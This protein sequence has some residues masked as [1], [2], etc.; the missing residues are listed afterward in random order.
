MAAIDYR[1]LSAPAQID[2]STFN[3]GSAETAQ[4]LA[5]AFHSFSGDASALG[6]ALNADAGAK[7]GGA[8]GASDNPAPKEGI[9]KYTAYSKAYNHSAEVA[10]VSKSQVDAEANITRIEQ[11]NQGNLPAYQAAVGGYIKGMQ[12]ATPTDYWPRLQPMIE[13]RVVAGAA[14][15]HGQ[16]VNEIK[17]QTLDT[18]YQG[19]DARTALTLKSMDGPQAFRDQA[20]T[21]AVADNNAQIDAL[22]KAG[23]MSAAEANAA[24]HKFTS[25]LQDAFDGEKLTT[26]VDGLMALA[27]GNVE[28]GDRALAAM[29]ARTDLDSHDKVA[30][31][32]QYQKEREQLTF[33]RS[34]THSGDLVNLA[35]TLAGGGYGANIEAQAHQ[36]YKLGATSVGEFSSQIEASVRNERKHAED[37]AAMAAVLDALNKGHGLDPRETKQVEA[38]D[39]LF[40]THAAQAGEAPG[41]ERYIAGAAQFAR[42]LNIVPTSVLSW[43]RIGL[44]SGDPNQAA[45]AAAAVKRIQDANPAA[46][47]FQEDPKIQTFASLINDNLTAGLPAANAYALAHKVMEVTPEQKKLLD[48]TYSKGKFAQQN[49]DA[50]RTALK[51]SP[52]I[53]PHF[54]SHVP[55]APVSLQAD[56]EQ[57]TRQYFTMTGGDINKSRDL[58]G[59]AV[60]ALWG[61]TSMNGEPELTK[62]APEK[63]YGISPDVIRADVAASLKATGFTGDPASVRLVPNGATDRTK[64]RVWS[65][66]KQETDGSIDAVLDHKNQP[67][68]YQLPLGQSFEAARRSVLEEKLRQARVARDVARQN[69]TDQIALEKQFSEYYLRPGFRSGMGAR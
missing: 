29:Q 66:L 57:L 33:E 59:K 19:M 20:M 1:Q 53:N 68:L 44:L 51:S 56:Y 58:A 52:D 46:A 37:G 11:D 27:R 5:Q 2:T 35:A 13:A 24:R 50:L 4:R 38:V 41:S 39:L 23:T 31:A 8:A 22:L 7:A 63:V 18:F 49:P 65:L 9:L 55:D 40:Q 16:E 67:V 69:A 42:Q 14:R 61:T 17:Q 64:G 6:Q 10:Y 15:V 3:D 30:I 48:E 54:W 21:A 26:A 43:A 34:R 47:P 45:T 12:A 28:N 60:L 62:Y 36:L 32:Q 25:G